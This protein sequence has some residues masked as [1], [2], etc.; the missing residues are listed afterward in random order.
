MQPYVIWLGVALY[1]MLFFIVIQIIREGPPPSGPLQPGKAKATA[2][3]M[4]L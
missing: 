3:Q 2:V 1:V 4:V